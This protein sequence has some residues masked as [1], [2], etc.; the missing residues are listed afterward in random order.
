MTLYWWGWENGSFHNERI[1]SWPRLLLE[2]SILLM[3]TVKRW[4]ELSR[5]EQVEGRPVRG[6][7]PW[8][9]AGY[10]LWPSKDRAAESSE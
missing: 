5:G 4:R 3:A 7:T 2:V 1:W 6:G 9:T 8:L 10:V